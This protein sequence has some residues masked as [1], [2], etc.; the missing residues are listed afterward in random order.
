MKNKSEPAPASM[1]PARG[2]PPRSRAATEEMRARIV[3]AA[4][5]LFAREGYG[6]VSMR[7]IAAAAGCAPGALYAY[8]PAKRA[9]LHVLWEDIFAELAARLT[10]VAAQTPDPVARLTALASANAHF[11]LERPDDY[12]AIFLIEDAPDEPGGRYFADTSASLEGLGVFREAAAEAIAAG[13]LS[14]ADPGEVTHMMLAAV[15]GLAH[16]LI[17]IPEYGW[18]DAETLVE[19]TVSALVRGL[20]T[21]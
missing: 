8:F 10:L 21:R 12:R 18:A 6:G 2:R 16:S 15:I 3:R 17:T 9:L 4:R 1:P 20:E 14:A 7:K 13:R 5:D 19:G 11:W